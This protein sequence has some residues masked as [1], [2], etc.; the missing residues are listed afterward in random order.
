ME[1]FGDQRLLNRL[2]VSVAALIENAGWAG[3]MCC[4]CEWAWL[5]AFLCGSICR[6]LEP[7]HQI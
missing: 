5:G 3:A 6:G 4:S 1:R 7:G 2:T